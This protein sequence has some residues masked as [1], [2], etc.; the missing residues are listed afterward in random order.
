MSTPLVPP[1]PGH[2]DL[3]DDELALVTSDGQNLAIKGPPINMQTGIKSPLPRSKAGLHAVL[4]CRNLWVRA[5]SGLSG[6]GR[7]QHET[8]IM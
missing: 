1:D 3:T 6:M 7:C 2:V 4:A 5:L 8:P